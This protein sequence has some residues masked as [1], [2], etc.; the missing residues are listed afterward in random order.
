MLTGFLIFL[1]LVVGL[2]AIPVTMTYRLSWKQSFS[3]D[4][5][6]RWAFGLIRTGASSDRVKSQSADAEAAEPKVGQGGRSSGRK[7]NVL[8]AIRRRS[9]RR[10]MIKF[11]SD[12]WFAVRKTNV[13]L[14]VRLGLGDPADTGQLWAVIGPITGLFAGSGGVSVAM[15]PDFLDSTFELDSSGTIR[16]V[17]LQ[18]IYIVLALLLSPA[19]WPGVILMRTPG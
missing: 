18:L 1:L 9:F 17:P 4:L 7:P 2:L 6:L 16:L 12:I 14:L 19:F 10:R 15:E 5:K 8:A 13:R 11:L 3:G